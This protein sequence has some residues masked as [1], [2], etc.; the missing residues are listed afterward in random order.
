MRSYQ[1]KQFQGIR[2]G[3]KHSLKR[4][5]QHQT[6]MTVTWDLEKL[7][8]STFSNIQKL[9]N[10]VAHRPAFQKMLKEII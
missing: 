1:E 9:K 10:F 8:I 6:Q 4:K 2:K 3:Q 7:R 5:H